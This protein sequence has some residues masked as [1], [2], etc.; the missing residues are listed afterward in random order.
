VGM[1][2]V[3]SSGSQRRAEETIA[4]RDQRPR[5]GVVYM[6]T[7]TRS[8]SA[9]L[10]TLK[11]ASI[12]IFYSPSTL[13]NGLKS[14]HAYHAWRQQRIID[15]FATTSVPTTAQMIAAGSLAHVNHR[16]LSEFE[17]KRLLATWGVSC[18]RHAQAASADEAVTAAERLGYP[19]V[20][21]ADSAS[22]LHKTEAGVVR[23]GL[24]D[25]DQVRTAFTEISA[26]VPG[27]VV[28]QEMVTDAVEVI[29]GVA[30]DEQLGPM[31]LFGTGGVQVEVYHDVAV[32]HCPITSFEAHTMI[33]QVK[34]ARLLQGYRGRPPADIAAL[35]QTLVDVSHLAVHLHGIL[36][37]LDINPLM[38]LPEGK[39]LK[40]A[41]ALVIL[42]PV[43]V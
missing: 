21:K 5:K 38:V 7:G 30:Y 25:A 8:E 11:A 36:T 29:V 12:P 27:G 1:L 41:D 14:L 35:A 24:R 4:L 15:G 34:G 10:A 26:R 3:A 17:S 43:I 28:V 31:L 22:I 19:V 37:E 16:T 32:R 2:V 18:T 40:A 20:L 9:G 23:L 39:G 6:W 42:K 13:A 33:Q